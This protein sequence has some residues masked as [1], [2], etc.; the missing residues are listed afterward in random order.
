M[1]AS[2]GVKQEPYSKEGE[3]PSLEKD[4][5]SS[6]EQQSTRQEKRQQNLLETYCL[7]DKLQLYWSHLNPRRRKEI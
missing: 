4:K 7:E 6:S 3:G 2:L 1:V 5:L